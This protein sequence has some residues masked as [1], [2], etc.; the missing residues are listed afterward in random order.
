MNIELFIKYLIKL[1]VLYS[2]FL[3]LSHGGAINFGRLL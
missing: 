1:S 2:T 3:Y